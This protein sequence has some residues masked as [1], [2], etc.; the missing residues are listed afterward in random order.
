M[1]WRTVCLD[2][3]LLVVL[4]GCPRNHMPGGAFDRAAHKDVKE[5]LERYGCLEKD[6]MDM[7]NGIEDLEELEECL[8]ECGS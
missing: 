1:R 7:C 6:Y 8:K 4:T 5:L 2:V 3:S